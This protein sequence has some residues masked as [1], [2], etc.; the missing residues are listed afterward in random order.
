M[1]AAVGMSWLCTICKVRSTKLQ[2]LSMKKCRGYC[3]KTAINRGRDD[4][5]DRLHSLLKSGTLT[6]CGICGAFSE[7]R[8]GRLKR[9]C[10][11][12]PP[13]QLGS[14]GVRAQL[15]RLRAGKHPVTM[16]PLPPMTRVDGTPVKTGGYS[17][18]NGR[19]TVDDGFIPYVP[20]ELVTPIAVPTEARTDRRRW[21]L[22]G[23]IRM[24]QAAEA[25]QSK[26]KRRAGRH[27]EALH[28]VESFVKGSD[29]ETCQVC[30]PDDEHRMFWQMLGTNLSSS[31]DPDRLAGIPSDKPAV[32]QYTVKPSRVMRLAGPCNQG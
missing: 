4:D 16:L 10:M 1:R 24:K 7:S 19:A 27:A 15:E 5:H 31:S 23:R 11:G 32:K 29:N 25:R 6:W 22:H 30:E 20:G 8:V 21:L 3:E 18:L 14:G 12:P 13:R 26:K 17:R 2:R 28:L 9:T